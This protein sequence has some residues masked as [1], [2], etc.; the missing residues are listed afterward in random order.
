MLTGSCTKQSEWHTDSIQCEWLVCLDVLSKHRGNIQPDLHFPSN[1]G[2]LNNIE[3]RQ[4]E[5]NILAYTMKYAL[6]SFQN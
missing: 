1:F 3:N 6:C 4:S 5:K 2:A